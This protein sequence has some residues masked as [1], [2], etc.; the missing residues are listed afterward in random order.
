MNLD[1]WDTVVTLRKEVREGRSFSPEEFA[2]RTRGPLC[3]L[4][5]AE[6]RAFSPP[7]SSLSREN[8]PTTGTSS[9]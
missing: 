7:C 4:R 9:K 2:L 1:P 6:K 8:P 5:P 3:P